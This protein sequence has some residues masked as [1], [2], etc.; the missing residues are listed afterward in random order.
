M[1]DE[2]IVY[3]LRT[4]FENAT[5][6]LRAQGKRDGG[7]YAE[8]FAEGVSQG[9]RGSGVPSPLQRQ[10]VA[11]ETASL[12]GAPPATGAP[13]ALSVAEK[14]AAVAALSLTERFG[15]LDDEQR[16]VIRTMKR[17][18]QAVAAEESSI[19]SLQRERDRQAKAL[20]RAT[21]KL[22]RQEE[23]YEQQGTSK[24]AIAQLAAERQAYTALASTLSEERR[25]QL[26]NPNTPMSRRIGLEFGGNSLLQAERGQ[27]QG[28][29]FGNELKK[30][31]FGTR[32][33][34][35]QLSFGGSIGQVGRFTA[36][37]GGAY[38]LLYQLTNGFSA[39]AA[40]AINFT[41]AVADLNLASGQ[42][43]E[44][45]R[46]LADSL[47]N[48]AAAAGIAPSQGVSAGAQ[49]IG[50][51]GLAQSSAAEQ[52]A[53]AQQSVLVSSRIAAVG[54]TDLAVT[55]Q[56]LAGLARS[57]N[58]SI[59]RLPALEDELTFISR[60]IGRPVSEL[61]PAVASVGTLGAG[62]GFTTQELFAA[63]GQVTSTTGQSASGAASSFRQVLSRADDPNFG[64][65]VQEQFGIQADGKSLRDIFAEFSATNPTAEA[66][67]RFSLLFGRGASQQVAQILGGNFNRIEGLAAGASGAAGS[68]LGQ[69]VFDIQMASAGAQLKELG[70]QA[71]NL[72]KDLSQTG[73][74]DFLGLLLKAA[75]VTVEAL[76]KVV[77]TFNLIPA[78]LRTLVFGLIE[79]QLAIKA[80][81]VLRPLAGGV[82]AGLSAAAGTRLAGVAG[83]GA[84]AASSARL[85]AAG[86]LF[87]GGLLS[88]FQ[89]N[90][91]AEAETVTAAGVRTAGAALVGSLDATALGLRS[92]GLRNTAVLGRISQFN[93]GVG[94]VPLPAVEG[95]ASAASAGRLA[96]AGGALAGAGRGALAL[97]GGPVGLALIGATI[98]VAFVSQLSSDQ[99]EIA[100]IIAGSRT[101][102]TEAAARGDFAG[103][104]QSQ[105]VA[106]GQLSAGG[107]ITGL[108]TAQER[109][110]GVSRATGLASLY[111]EFDQAVKAE[112]ELARARGEGS[113]IGDLASLSASDLSAALEGL[114][115]SGETAASTSVLLGKAIE[116]LINPAEKVIAATQI[117]A[118][119]TAGT[120]GAIP[121]LVSSIPKSLLRGPAV[122]SKDPYATAPDPSALI[123][124]ESLART[125][126][127]AQPS[128]GQIS[129]TLTSPEFQKRA[130]DRLEGL[131]KDNGSKALDPAG[132]DRIAKLQADFYVQESGIKDPTRAQALREGLIK[133]FKEQIASA[134]GSQTPLLSR[135]QLLAGISS[136]TGLIGQRSG[137]DGIAELQRALGQIDDLR[138]K[139]ADPADA[140]LPAVIE[141]RRA[142]VADLAKATIDDNLRILQALNSLDPVAAARKSQ[143]ELKKAVDLATASGNTDLVVSV[144]EGANRAQIAIVRASLEAV[145]R[146]K[147]AALAA[148]PVIAALGAAAFKDSDVKGSTDASIGKRNSAQDAVAEAQKR[149]RLFLASLARSVIPDTNK[150][151]GLGSNPSAGAADSPEDIA[152][153]QTRAR[154]AGNNSAIVQARASIEIAQR[155][156][157]AAKANTVA[158]YTALAALREGQ[159]Q[160]A[161][162]E[163]AYA[164]D[165]RKLNSDLTDPVA[166]A[167]NAIKDARAKLAADIKSGQGADVIAADRVA[168]RQ[169][170]NQGEAAAFQQRFNDAQTADRLGRIS[171]Q[172]Y[173]RYL[174]NEHDRLTAITK[175]T[176]QQQEQLDQ[177]DSAIQ[178]ANEQLQGQFNLGDIKV[179]SPYEVRRYIAETANAAKQAA[180]GQGTA[181]TAGFAS[182]VSAS[183]VQNQVYINGADPVAVEA[184]LR[185]LISGSS[186][187]TATSSSGRK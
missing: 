80:F 137:P 168:V 95:A 118:T 34:G 56:N 154:V 115:S 53:G 14:R 116:G 59:D 67:N 151:Y 104:A 63:I 106:A 74:L 121:G 32:D 57:L 91:V 103:A 83:E 149:L 176:R 148:L 125:R 136:A 60:N 120:T 165:Q 119:A 87:R 142:V 108:F 171:H 155:D 1:P 11:A 124:P 113:A 64:R 162:A 158:Y 131:L 20:A 81:G 161:L 145:V 182:T 177:V 129:D 30:G 144:I 126:A 33:P 101:G 2:E 50:L 44:T 96:S 93:P 58:I 17:N 65:K 140:Q 186:I 10:R 132:L 179:P 38:G 21:Q 112:Q 25:R 164:S 6:D 41:Q 39:A 147:Q 36:L 92:A 47:G 12:V 107:G 27:Y 19:I 82:A 79:L 18:I 135:E 61:L 55:Q 117:S 31:F 156:L 40:E 173:L 183:S 167:R 153:A 78:P 169:A 88:P 13:T 29:P 62:A 146:A 70:A 72:G 52:S 9:G 181:T 97:V 69:E 122:A 99:D 89:R 139:A 159:R 49:A 7:V 123:S 170:I 26:A 180:T 111:T 4:Q 85:G 46:G 15:Q 163:L 98:G 77:Q 184:I 105:Q 16:E 90:A 157:A 152:N 68:G 43:A 24:G 86:G 71:L 114:Q 75:L 5:N 128:D 8:G 37:Y 54:G 172:A 51:F 109:D 110:R 175:R 94:A 23:I 45:N 84:V 22:S 42:T 130:Q 48:I 35:D 66:L 178:A 76:D 73:I 150:G 3:S 166:Q 138:S 102:T 160:L 100:Q 174:N 134:G 187:S 141:A 143:G 28:S 127:N 133:Y 185:R